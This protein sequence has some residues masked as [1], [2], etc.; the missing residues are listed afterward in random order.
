MKIPQ[1]PKNWQEMLK[2]D[3]SEIFK[4]LE[5]KEV[6]E[7][8]TKYNNKKYLHWNEVRYREFPKD[9]KPEYIWAL[10]KIFRNSQYRRFHF[11]KWAFRYVLLDE[12]QKK[13]HL[14]DCQ[15]A[16][17]LGSSLDSSNISGISGQR[18]IISSLMEEAIASSQLEG[19]A[20]TRK[21]AKELLR[22][23]KRPRNYS[24]RMIVNGYKTIQKIVQMKEKNITPEQILE[25]HKGI[26]EGTLKDKKYEGNFR[27]N[28]E[29]VVGDSLE[30]ERI[31]HQPPDYKDIPKLMEEFCAFVNSDNGE[32]IH[33]IIKGIMLHFFV[34]Y[35]HPFE[36][37]NGR[38]ARTIFYWYVLTRGYWLFE[39]MAISRIILRS[40]AKYGMAYLH[41]ETDENDL[42][43]FIDYNLTA[44]EEALHDTEEYINRKQKEQSE[45]L[46]LIKSLKNINLRQAEILKKFIKDSDKSFV[47]NEIMNTYGVAYDTA[48]NDL[49]YLARLGYLD[50]TKI[51]KKFLF[52]LS[53]DKVINK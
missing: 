2:K 50:K 17:R 32:F 19:A 10:M 5:N 7:L 15:A 30:P 47:V 48:R 52:R 23:N 13:L 21:V 6:M 12:F 28:N 11:G 35:I 29:V 20:T 25:L 53:K 31:Y 42:T 44:I 9:V 14:L 18:Y 45:A 41:T 39:Y 46:Q 36:D 8:V 26:T 51:Q 22:Y 24:E 3:S 40:K 37:G 16:G 49:L 43:Y 33:P 1:K 27:D 4:L 38:T 34:G